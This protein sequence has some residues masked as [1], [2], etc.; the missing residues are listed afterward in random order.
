MIRTFQMLLTAEPYNVLCFFFLHNFS[1]LPGK[2]NHFIPFFGFV[3]LFY[4]PHLNLI[5]KLHL[6]YYKHLSIIFQ[7]VQR[8]QLIFQFHSSCPSHPR[9]GGNLP[10]RALP[11]PVA[12]GTG[13]GTAVIIEIPLL[14]TAVVC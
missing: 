13:L 11:S 12:D 14:F 5:H 6:R 1:I 2:Y 8:N 9:P 4:K 10:P 3:L 7:V